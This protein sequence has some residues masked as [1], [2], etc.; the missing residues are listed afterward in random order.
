MA[1]APS[2]QATLKQGDYILLGMK[3]G[4]R[5]IDSLKGKDR[6]VQRSSEL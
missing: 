5:H 2:F 4:Q 6:L 3:I 1:Q